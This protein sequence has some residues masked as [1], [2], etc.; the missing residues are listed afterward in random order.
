MA[1]RKKSTTDMNSDS[2]P[3]STASKKPAAATTP[4][5][6]AK[7]FAQLSDRK[8]NI[9]MINASMSAL[10]VVVKKERVMDAIGAVRT[11]FGI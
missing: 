6:A 9:E 11:E 10:N 1:V 7:I 2:R 4:G 3:V 8:I 5:V